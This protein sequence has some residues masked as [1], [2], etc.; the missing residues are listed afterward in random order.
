MPAQAGG[1]LPS[2]ADGR[3]VR[4]MVV[5][6][7]RPHLPASRRSS[8]VVRSFE[9]TDAPSLC[10][11]LETCE[12]GP[13]RDGHGFG[14]DEFLRGL[15]ENG[16]L[17][18][19]VGVWG[20]D[21]IIG[22]VALVPV[23]SQ[24]GPRGHSV[25]G[26]LLVVHPSF[27][28]YTGLAAALMEEA[29]TAAFA[30]GY[31]RIDTH[32]EVGNERAERMYR[33]LHFRQVTNEPCEDGSLLFESHLPLIVRYLITTFWSS[34]YRV[35]DWLI[36]PKALRRLLPR[37]AQQSGIDVPLP[38]F[39]SE[40]VVYE[41]RLNPAESL[42]L[43]IDRA[44][45]RVTAV[46]GERQDFACWPEGG[47]S[48]RSG[49]E[50][51]IHFRMRS[52]Y[53]HPVRAVLSRGTG[54]SVFDE[55]LEA[56]DERSGILSVPAS[57]PGRHV[58]ELTLLLIDQNSSAPLQ[59]VSVTT[60]FDVRPAPVRD[61]HRFTRAPSGWTARGSEAGCTIDAATGELRITWGGRLAAVELWPEVGPPFPG[62]HKRPIPRRLEEV[63]GRSEPGLELRSGGNQWIESHHELRKPAEHRGL[64]KLLVR[65]SFTMLEEGVLRIDTAVELVGESSDGERWLRTWPRVCLDAPELILPVPGGSWRRW[66]DDDALPYAMPN[67]EFMR[68]ASPS[69]DV[70]DHAAPWAAFTGAG[71]VA[72]LVFPGASE[73]RFGGRWMP[74]VLY[75]IPALSRAT[76]THH[77]PPYVLVVGDGGPARL[78]DV[79]RDIA[80]GRSA[81]SS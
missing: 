38:W 5:T 60:W 3:T 50:V 32:I 81:S 52:G 30:S 55:V 69:P 68:A 40:V 75:R 23:S 25:F 37:P 51:T 28:G 2:I 18:L 73:L 66:S 6:N 31:D 15:E 35:S 46:G 59:S 29:G 8:Y 27:R 34:Q 80:A 61:Q 21:Q 58:V 45:D 14:P 71:L 7:T 16:T 1:P 41:L 53:D 77:L 42:V 24:R 70:A 65:R 22:C 17:E 20:A 67:Y 57:I 11:L 76:P 19:F 36:D 79:W 12:W 44:I 48:F 49:G 47:R 9:K 78:A 72:G 10:D 33:R 64:D 56:G 39:G 54:D 4:S 26:D 43:M 74:S 62:G 63:T 13:Y